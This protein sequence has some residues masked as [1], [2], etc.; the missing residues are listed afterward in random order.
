METLAW[1]GFSQ[2][3]FAAIIMMAKKNRSVP[4][5]LL[6][7][8]LCLLSIAF[9]TCAINYAIFGYTL[10]SSSFLLFNPTFYL[11]VK[12]LIKSDFQPKWIHLLHLVPF[13][14][15]ETLAYVLH[16]PYV[17]YGFLAFDSTFLFRYF[18]SF[19]SILSWIVYN[20]AIASIIYKHRL[21]LLDEFS[22]IESNKKVGWLIFI[23]VF[24]NAFCLVSVAIGAYSVFADIAFP[25]SPVYNFSA[26]LL[27]V[28]ILGFYGLKQ[29]VIYSE[30]K[31]GDN[32]QERYLKSQLSTEKKEKIRLKLIDY[33]EK[34][35]P[36]LNPDLNMD[37]LSDTLK[38]PKHH[39]TEVL[40]VDIGKNFFQFVNE[41]RVE[42][43]KKRLRKPKQH[44]SIEAIGY[45]CGFSSKSSYF[46]VFK[47]ITGTTPSQYK[48]LDG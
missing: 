17:M 11:Y 21:R 8:W 18:F 15:F 42:E 46:T 14:F 3:L 44:F 40:N 34:N 29:E 37:M 2:A 16:E 41:Y 4:D 22:N 43:V 7:A 28:Y 45:D 32:L 25:L 6:T 5:K 31:N 20:L 35:Q 30:R 19:A 39:L 27:M 48:G 13:V 33:F 38:I 36:Y 24:Y 12:S 26:L 1:I 9:L 47:K 10:L 23:V